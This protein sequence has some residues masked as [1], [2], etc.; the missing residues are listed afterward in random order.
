MEARIFAHLIRLGPVPAR[1]LSLS[2]LLMAGTVIAGL[3]ARFVPLGLPRFIVKY[4]GSTLWALMIYWVVSTILPSWRIYSAAVLAAT[5][6]TAVEFVKLYHAGPLDAFRHSLA[7]IILLGQ[8][9]SVWDLVAYW[10]AIAIGAL[11]DRRLRSLR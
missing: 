3:T 9:F 5:L 4:G 2:F 11:V 1:P 6:A 8:F 10:L 7:G